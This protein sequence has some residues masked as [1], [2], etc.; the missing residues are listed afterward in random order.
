LFSFDRGFLFLEG[1][2]R[3]EL[4]REC[5]CITIGIFVW[6]LLKALELLEDLFY[7]LVLVVVANVVT[8]FSICDLKF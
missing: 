7:A 2:Q 1:F 5:L 8:D 4:R 3:A 6:R